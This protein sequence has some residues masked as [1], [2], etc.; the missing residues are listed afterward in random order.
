MI[1]TESFDYRDAG[2]RDAGVLVLPSA[3][4]RSDPARSITSPISEVRG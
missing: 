3:E 4:E 1:V 2:A